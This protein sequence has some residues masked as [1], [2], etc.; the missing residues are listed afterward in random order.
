MFDQLPWQPV[1]V[2]PEPIISDQERRNHMEF[3]RKQEEARRRE[4]YI[5]LRMSESFPSGPI[6]GSDAD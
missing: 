4:W 6:V 3:M 1:H 2:R 5:A